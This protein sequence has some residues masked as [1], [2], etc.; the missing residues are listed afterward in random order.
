[1]H[2]VCHTA[3]QSL[4][5]VA[6]RAFGYGSYD[7]S[8]AFKSTNVSVHILVPCLCTSSDKKLRT[9]RISDS[10]AE[11]RNLSHAISLSAA[12]VE[13]VTQ[14]DRIHSSHEAGP[15]KQSFTRSSTSDS[16]KAVDQN[17]R[18]QSKLPPDIRSELMPEHVA[19]IMDGNSRWAKERGLSSEAGHEAGVRVLRDIVR[20][21][22]HWDIKALTL[23]AF[24]T[25]NW[26]RPKYEVDFLMDLF[27]RVFREQI[28][29]LTRANICMRFIGDLAQLPPQLQRLIAEVHRV[30]G[31]NTGLKLSIAMSYS[32]RQDI[33]R[34]CRSIASMAA[35][36]TLDVDS[37]DERLLEDQLATSWMGGAIR[38]PDLL[39]RT[40]GEQRLSNFLLW[41]LAYTELYF[42]EAYWPDFDQEHLKSAL[43]AFQARQR[44][45]GKR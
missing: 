42:S 6:C 32:G 40:S 18:I 38:S 22:C 41:Q 45:Y 2:S 37:I 12:A 29:E 19:I 13:A 23:F 39:I 27:E 4:V 35:E 7:Q 21:A 25:E 24:S 36:G 33:V 16:D 17:D 28:P 5:Q 43:L 15:S 26:F 30:S 10:G 8:H 1:M 3:G 9:A 14:R 44:R 20:T 11:R 31:G 34:A